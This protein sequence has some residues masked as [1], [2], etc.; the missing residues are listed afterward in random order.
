MWDARI[1]PTRVAIW[2]DPHWAFLSTQV[3]KVL[4]NPDAEVGVSGSPWGEG[5]CPE[6]A[7]PLG[8]EASERSGRPERSRSAVVPRSLD[9]PWGTAAG[10]GARLESAV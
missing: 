10:A 7:A 5:T 9:T 4:G 6:A 1:S 8:A 3:K 2:T